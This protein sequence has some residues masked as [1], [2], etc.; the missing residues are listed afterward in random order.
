MDPP[1]LTLAQAAAALGL[2]E[3]AVLE[4]VAGGHV[5]LEVDGIPREDVERVRAV[6]RRWARVRYPAPQN[7]EGSGAPRG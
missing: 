3:L 1:H 2:P 6:W 5:R 7:G 4:L